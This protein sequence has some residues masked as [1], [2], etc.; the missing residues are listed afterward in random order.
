[1]M[2]DGKRFVWCHEAPVRE[3]VPRERISE[4][5]LL[6]RA[7]MRGYL[8]SKDH[9]ARAVGV[10]KSI[11]AILLYTPALPVFLLLGRHVFMTYLI[12]DCDHLGKVLGVC[13]FPLFRERTF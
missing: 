8:E 9:R 6:K 4:A 3:W 2:N 11:A 12:R 1:M 10:L 5:Y 13:G 7:L